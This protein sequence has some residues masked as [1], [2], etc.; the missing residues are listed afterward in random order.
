MRF[1]DRFRRGYYWGL[2]EKTGRNHLAVEWYSG[3]VDFHPVRG[4]CKRIPLDSRAKHTGW[5]GLRGLGH[6]RSCL[7]GKGPGCLPLRWVLNIFS[8]FPASIQPSYLT[9]S[10]VGRNTIRALAFLMRGAL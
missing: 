6:T 4:G 10:S 2:R 7:C 5:T 1:S 9:T 8:G 3:N